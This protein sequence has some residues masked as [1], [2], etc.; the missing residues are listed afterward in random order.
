MAS[1]SVE[2][3]IKLTKNGREKVYHLDGVEGDLQIIPLHS[4]RRVV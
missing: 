1:H 3:V 2:V 4:I